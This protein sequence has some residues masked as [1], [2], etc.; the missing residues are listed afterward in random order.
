[1]WPKRFWNINVQAFTVAPRT[2]GKVVQNAQ[3]CEIY[4]Y[5][6]IDTAHISRINSTS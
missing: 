3:K 6:K 1:M 2:L 5:V 4:H